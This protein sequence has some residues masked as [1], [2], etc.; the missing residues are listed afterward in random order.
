MTDYDVEQRN[1]RIP[2][3]STVFVV[4]TTNGGDIP[5]WYFEKGE[6]GVATYIDQSESAES[7]HYGVQYAGRALIYNEPDI[8]RIENND[9]SL[10]VE[11]NYGDSYE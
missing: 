9:G 4:E 11:I 1:P 5:R 3:E 7:C 8:D 10:M 2:E 6:N